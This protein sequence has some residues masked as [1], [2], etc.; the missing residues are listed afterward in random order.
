MSRIL[1]GRALIIVRALLNYSVATVY[2]TVHR[3]VC[4]EWYS[5]SWRRSNGVRKNKVRGLGKA[6]QKRVKEVRGGTRIEAIG[7]GLG[8]VGFSREMP[9]AKQTFIALLSRLNA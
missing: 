8:Y 5:K 9:A 2:I 1:H 7:A 4:N 3:E 6:G